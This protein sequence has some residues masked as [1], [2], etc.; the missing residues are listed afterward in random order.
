MSLYTIEFKEIQKEDYNLIGGKGYNLGDMLKNGFS[1]PNGFCITTNAYIEFL[2]YNKFDDFVKRASLEKDQDL[3]GNVSKSIRQK[4]ERG[5]VPENIK[6]SIVNAYKK[7]GVNYSYAIRSSA[8]AEDTDFASFAGQQ[9]TYLN[10]KGEEELI[11]SVIKCWASLFTERAMLYRMRNNIPFEDVI[12]SIAV[13]RMVI[14][15]S[16]GIMFTA[17]PITGHRQEVCIDAGFGLG[18]AMVS[19]IVTPDTYLVDTRNNKIIE[20]QLG[21][22]ESQIVTNKDGGVEKVN[23]SKSESSKQVLSDSL[24]IELANYG[25]KIERHYNSSQDIEWCIENGKIYF[26]QSRPITSLYPIPCPMPDDNKLHSY[27]SFNHVQMM[28]KPISPLGIDILRRLFHFD[29]NIKTD[30]DYRFLKSSGGRIYIDISILLSDKLLSRFIVSFI[31]NVSEQIKQ[32]ILNLIE[33][34]EFKENIYSNKADTKAL[35]RFLLARVLGGVKNIFF[36]KPVSSIAF[37]NEYID[38]RISKAVNDLENAKEEEKFKVME[39]VINFTEDFKVLLPRMMAGIGSFAILKNLEMK[40][41]GS[42]EYTNRIVKGLE[43]NI[44]TEMGLLTGDLADMVG[45]SPELI[46][47]FEKSNSKDIFEKVEKLPDNKEFKKLFSSFI[48]KYGMRCSGEIDIKNK[49]WK[50]D[51]TPLIKSILAMAKTS[52]ENSHRV[53]YE[54]LIKDSKKAKVELIEEVKNKKG[55]VKAKFIK[56]IANVLHCYL[57]I[58][59]HPKY[60]IVNLLEICKEICLSKGNNMVIKGQ[61]EK[62]ED[63]FYLTWFEVKSLEENKNNIKSIIK[64]RKENYLYYEKITPPSIL[65]NDGEC[66]RCEV[67]NENVKEGTLVG[68]GVSAGIVEGIAKVI[69]DPSEA[70]INKGEILIAPYTDPGWT[71]LFINASGLVTEIGGML[72]HGTVVAR[73]YGIPAV[74]SLSN[75]TKKIKSGQIIRVNGDSGVV[76]IINDVNLG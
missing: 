6:N 46:E 45:K 63:I 18:E 29:S 12:M 59:E 51:L 65:T 4:L 76:E 57:P 72:T 50:E 17:N 68:T 66:V 31:G 30:S 32:G 53:E 64:K 22:K 36:K 15:Q 2:E 49:R 54:K 69:L 10:V 71:P 39:Q 43:G 27:I 26:V 13:Q 20:K 48:N 75:A 11:K 47:I 35:K 28:I 24:I 58:R 60:M 38:K 37:L 16:S 3:I 9:D 42:N 44:T 41:L 7:S 52:T 61:L 33:K 14:P 34:D 55:R 8:I 5:K 25:K 73:E 74:V 70:S 56:R 21:K 67:I 62:A 40:W 1:V 23:L 19:G